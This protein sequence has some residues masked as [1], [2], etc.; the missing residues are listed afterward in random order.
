MDCWAPR[1]ARP[2]RTNDLVRTEGRAGCGLRGYRTSRYAR[3][4]DCSCDRGRRGTRRC[5]PDVW[6]PAAGRASII[7]VLGKHDRPA[8]HLMPAATPTPRPGPGFRVMRYWPAVRVRARQAARRS[9]LEQRA[10][11]IAGSRTSRTGTARQPGSPGL[12]GTPRR[13]RARTDHTSHSSSAT[14]L[15]WS[16]GLIDLV[17]SSR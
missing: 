16:A 7:K 6:S 15:R 1:L 4:P 12:P 9:S 11:A 3:S 14:C 2:R 8:R 17:R 13:P 5:C 10:P